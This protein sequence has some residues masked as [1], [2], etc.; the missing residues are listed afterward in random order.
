M[1]RILDAVMSQRYRIMMLSG[2]M[3]MLLVFGRRVD[4]AEQSQYMIK[5]NRICNTVTVYEKDE[6]GQYTIPIKAMVCSVGVGNRTI[7]GTFQTRGKYRWKALMGDVWGQYATRI[8]GGILFHSVYY[9]ENGNP[10]S[11]ATKE[12]NKLGTAAS[13]G[14]IR[15][16]VQDAKWIYDNCS[17]GTTVMI[18]DD[19]DHPGPLGKPDAIK[20]ATSIRWDPT[21]PD[22]KNPYNDRKPQIKGVKNTTIAWGVSIDLMEGI[23]AF[24]SAGADITDMLTVKGEFSNHIPGEY[25]LTYIIEDELGKKVSK[26][27]LIVVEEPEQQ[28]EITG[29]NDKVADG[30]TEVDEAFALE[31]VE[32]YCDKTKLDPGLIQVTIEMAEEDHY[33]LTYQIW[34][35]NQV[36]AEEKSSVLIDTRPPMI[37]GDLNLYYAE[38]DIPLQKDVLDGITAKDN[39]TD[40]EQIAMSAEIIKKNDGRYEVIFH[41]VDEAGNVANVPAVIHYD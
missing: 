1:K 32:V 29:I 16:S 20:I 39:Y 37:L 40:A 18:Y 26:S 7:K 13:H 25:Q 23:S 38:G 22:K 12:F 27:R 3:I 21:D 6:E 17:L 36:V 11:L 14:C 2:F 19:K 34:N 31:G 8:V 4:A 15:L 24:S 9:Y 33:V 5:V 10:A 35:D 41:A 28:P 30:Y